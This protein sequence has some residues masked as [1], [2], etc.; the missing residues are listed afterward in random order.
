[1]RFYI[2]RLRSIHCK[3]IRNQRHRF[4]IDARVRDGVSA[5]AHWPLALVAGPFHPNAR[6]RC[7]ALAA[8]AEVSAWMI[9][10]WRLHDTSLAHSLYPP[11]YQVL[12]GC[13]PVFHVFSNAK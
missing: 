10:V 1:M 13:V 2:G 3:T 7:K 6:P 5:Q 4:Q 8:F 11:R 9:G 12:E